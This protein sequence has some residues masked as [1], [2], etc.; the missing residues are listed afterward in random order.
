MSAFPP[1]RLI[2]RGCCPPVPSLL[3][4]APLPQALL[5]TPP[6]R[7]A[8]TMA[9]GRNEKYNQKGGW[10]PPRRYLKKEEIPLALRL[11]ATP[12]LPLR[13]PSPG[14]LAWGV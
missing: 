12:H 4:P 3:F 6:A 1:T 11:C 9:L 8:T 13:I 2:R 5:L 10:N 7:A 14:A